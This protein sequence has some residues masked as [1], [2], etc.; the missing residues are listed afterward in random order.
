MKVTVLI[1]FIDLTLGRSLKN[2]LL[3]NKYCQMPP[4]R[5]ASPPFPPPPVIIPPNSRP[6]HHH[7]L[8]E[9]QVSTSFKKNYIHQT[10]IK[11]S[12][13]YS[14][15]YMYMDVLSGNGCESAES[16]KLRHM[17]RMQEAFRIFPS[18]SELSELW[19]EILWVSLIQEG[20]P[21]P[22]RVHNAR[23]LL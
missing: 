12:R 5:S 19:T 7:N 16:A 11:P 18:R 22:S 3:I 15:T 6:Q 4:S 13:T 2:L 10:L 23:S 8:S 14:R 20:C 9:L 21:L 1:F 17:W